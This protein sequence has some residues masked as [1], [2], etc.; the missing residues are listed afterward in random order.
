MASRAYESCSTFVCTGVARWFTTD[1]PVKLMTFTSW[2]RRETASECLSEIYP[3]D[4]SKF[5]RHTKV[6]WQMKSD[7]CEQWTRESS[8]VIHGNSIICCNGSCMR[9]VLSL[10]CVSNDLHVTFPFQQLQQRRR[11]YHQLLIVTSKSMS[12][13]YTLPGHVHSCVYSIAVAD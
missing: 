13:N 6:F 11:A 8:E 4:C 9:L 1:F 10:E 12:I 7:N 3:V 5:K 2:L